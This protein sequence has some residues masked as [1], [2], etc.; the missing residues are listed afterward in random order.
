M[1]YIF[2]IVVS[3]KTERNKMKNQ[4]NRKVLKQKMAEALNSDL[5]TLS[6]EMKDILLD[7][8]ITAFES[9]K[10]ALSPARPSMQCFVEVGMKV[11]Q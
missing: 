10:K 1:T 5:E 7:D 8:L 4:N 6:A 2:S 11:S 9:R 3:A